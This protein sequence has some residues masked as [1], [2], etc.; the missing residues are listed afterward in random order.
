MN[1]FKKKMKEK[2]KI[3]SNE[4]YLDGFI[5]KEFLT[6]DSVADIYLNVSDK[7]ELIHPWTM[8]NQIELKQEVYDY[9]ENKT[10]MLGN[11]IPICMHI[12]GYSFSSKE[13]GM[14][15]HILKEHYAIELYKVQ[16][17]YNKLKHKIIGMISFGL[18]EIL[19]FLFS[20]SLWEAMDC[21]IYSFNQ[22][23][24]DRE[25][26]TQNLLM[27]VEYDKKEL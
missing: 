9:I 4:Q 11:H 27:S 15:R 6:E 2:I 19:G 26:V 10:S 21:M 18:L 1:D 16:K 8:G 3:Y 20:F 5:K 23:K 13:E 7:Y 25:A 17:L 24:H 12:A 22:V 14:I